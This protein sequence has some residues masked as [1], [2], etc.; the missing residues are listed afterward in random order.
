MLYADTFFNFLKIHVKAFTAF[1]TFLRQFDRL[2]AR[3]LDDH[4]EEGKRIINPILEYFWPKRYELFLHV[5][6]FT[7]NIF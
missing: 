2:E 6:L 4:F 7:Q 1:N 5:N 3:V